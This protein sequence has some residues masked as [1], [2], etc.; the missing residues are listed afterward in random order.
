MSPETVGSG[1]QIVRL[2]VYLGEDKLKDGRPLYQTVIRQARLE[3][4]AGATVHRASQGFGRSTRM[5]TTDVLFSQDLP[6]VIEIIDRADKIDA[7]ATSLESFPEI[8]LMTLEPVELRG[9]RWLES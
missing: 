6:V 4:M 9:S 1:R 3:R 7:F 2:R 8:G 5:H